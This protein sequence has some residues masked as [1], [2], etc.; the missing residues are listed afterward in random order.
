HLAPELGRAR[1][2]GRL[3]PEPR[4]VDER[5]DAAQPLTRGRDEPHDVLLDAHVRSHRDDAVTELARE[6]VEALDPARAHDDARA[7]GD[8]R[9][10]AGR[11]DAARRAGEDDAPV[12][13]RSH[14]RRLARR[15]GSGHR[16]TTAPL[17]TAPPPAGSTVTWSAS[18]SSASSG[19]STM[20]RA[21]PVA[22]G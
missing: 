4:V 8:G 21:A 17:G 13:E 18:G 11:T 16:T 5:V 7:L 22:S 20:R 3:P 1:R 15:H 9:G 14:A 19:A 2:H 10:H 12:L 6:R